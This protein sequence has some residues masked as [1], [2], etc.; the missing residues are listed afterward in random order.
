MNK[1]R[2]KCAIWSRITGYMR[3]TSSWNEAKLEEF[4]SRVM[5]KVD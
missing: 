4:K 2:T 1:K 5:F 3:P